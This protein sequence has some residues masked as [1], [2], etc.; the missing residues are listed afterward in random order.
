MGCNN[1][2]KANSP[3][4]EE[5]RGQ[6]VEK[7]EETKEI[8]KNQDINDEESKVARWIGTPE[9]QTHPSSATSQN[10]VKII[11]IG[12]KHGSNQR[13]DDSQVEIDRKATN[14]SHPITHSFKEFGLNLIFPESGNIYTKTGETEIR[15]KQ[16]EREEMNSNEE[17]EYKSI[18]VMTKLMNT[19]DS[20]EISNFTRIR[21]EESYIIIHTRTPSA[22]TF[23]LE[24]FGTYK[25]RAAN[26][27]YNKILNFTIES[28]TGLPKF[29]RIFDD[30]M[31]KYGIELNSPLE[32]VL[33]TETGEAKI[34]LKGRNSLANTIIMAQ[35][36]DNTSNSLIPDSTKCI[37]QDQINIMTIF[38]HAPSQDE[39]SLEI[40]AKQKGKKDFHGILSFTI[41]SQGE[42]PP[43][44]LTFP[45]YEQMEIKILNPESGLIKTQNG[46][47]KVQLQ[48][49]RELVHGINAELKKHKKDT[50]PL[51]QCTY[52]QYEDIADIYTILCHTPSPGKYYLTIYGQA[53]N[54]KTISAIMTY[55]VQSEGQATKYP[56]FYTT[57]IN[58]LEIK[59]IEPQCGVIYAEDGRAKIVLE[60]ENPE[61]L[62]YGRLKIVDQTSTRQVLNCT[63]S[64]KEGK[65]IEI[66]INTPDE[67][68]Y[69]LDI[70]GKSGI[71]G[72]G[73]GL[74][75]F[76]LISKG[77]A[78]Q[79]PAI[80]PK[81]EK[82]NMKVINPYEGIIHTDSGEI[83]IE[84]YTP[85]DIELS[86]ELKLRGEYNPLPK[87]CIYIK[88]LEKSTKVHCRTPMKGEFELEIY[89]KKSTSKKPNIFHQAISYSIISKNKSPGYAR[90][91]KTKEGF[92]IH[93]L[94]GELRKGEEYEFLIVSE[95]AIGV[96]LV[97]G[98]GQVVE[99]DKRESMLWGKEIIIR[100][101]EARTEL[102]IVIKY[103]SE[104]KYC[105]VLSEYVLI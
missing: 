100:Q 29:P 21:Y 84:L 15:L 23:R 82:Y 68:F 7:N 102:K 36:K 41:I 75:S 79:F 11:Q 44:P 53:P 86:A 63:K 101:D 81:F 88:Y 57:A 95:L 1:S 16:P 48:A 96:E 98:D 55:T 6:T 52:V 74:L 18:I 4:K 71:N 43:F 103:D 2:S 73:S 12:G 34:V 65:L 70:F 46:E 60:S 3:E 78:P 62:A 64:I 39:Y 69:N 27:K 91:Y 37:L 93:P 5:N 49:P 104:D 8:N 50:D 87:S 19:Q 17:L 76:E 24:I 22:G 45:S 13:T 58:D 56:K 14:S 35:L 51:P 47:G 26:K 66:Y 72:K 10:K 59:L 77:S 67:G 85:K 80:Y 90:I 38:I 20:Q 9:G 61:I 40:F 31:E 89:T 42:A 32:G 28:P 25:R 30:M 54:K 105:S 94:E 83:M 92:L 97:W 99:L 33:T